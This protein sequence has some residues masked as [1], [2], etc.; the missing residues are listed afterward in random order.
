MKR[1]LIFAYPCY[2]PSGGMCDLHSQFDNKDEALT[3]AKELI[4]DYVEV[5]DIQ[6][7][8]EIWSN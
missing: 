5:Y 6:E 7:D 4:D 1:Y 8:R 2:Y 3:R